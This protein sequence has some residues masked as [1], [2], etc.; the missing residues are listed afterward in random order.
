VND[1]ALLELRRLAAAVE[2]QA[3]ELPRLVREAVREALAE[4]GQQRLTPA[5]RAAQAAVGRLYRPHEAFTT[6]EAVSACAFDPE[7]LAALRRACN[8]DPQ[9]LGILLGQLAAAGAVAGGVRLVRLPPEAGV[10]RWVL[11]AVEP[12]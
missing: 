3:A 9:R 4:A 2:E 5:Q 6:S 10:R 11:E 7:A 12:F 1:P 8:A